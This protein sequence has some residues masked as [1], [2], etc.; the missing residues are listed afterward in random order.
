MK[1]KKNEIL[2]SLLCVFPSVLLITATLFIVPCVASQKEPDEAPAESVADE[3]NTTEG[4]FDITEPPFSEIPQENPIWG[5]EPTEYQKETEDRTDTI[6][7]SQ[8]T[9]AA[10]S[11]G[12]IEGSQTV[13]S[14]DLTTP[15]NMELPAT[16]EET[17]TNV[18]EEG[19]QTNESVKST[20]TTGSN[21]PDEPANIGEK[22]EESQGMNIV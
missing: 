12:A 20:E 11:E 10:I 15:E 19:S 6:T 2:V 9:E 22:I 7:I 21:P 3:E 8:P 17:T 14:T 5:V 4:M 18:S 1:W 13:T 16:P